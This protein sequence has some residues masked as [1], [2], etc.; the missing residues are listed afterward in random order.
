MNIDHLS[1]LNEGLRSRGYAEDMIDEINVWPYAIYYP[2]YEQYTT[3]F[4]EALIQDSF[5]YQEKRKSFDC[6][7]KIF[8]KNPDVGW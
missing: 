6:V 2:Y 8:Y 1:T 4:S 3:I 7:S 5:H